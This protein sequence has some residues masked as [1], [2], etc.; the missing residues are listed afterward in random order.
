MEKKKYVPGKS[1]EEAKQALE[2]HKG[3]KPGEYHS[4]WKDAADGLL[5]DIQNR[6]PFSYH[7]GADPMYR[8][9]VDQYVRLGRKAMMDTM[10]KASAMTGGYGNSYAQTAGQQTY[11]EYLES[12]NDRLPEFQKMARDTYQAQGEDLLSRYEALSQ[13]EKDAYGQYQKILEQY[14]AQQD[15]LQGAYDREKEQDYHRYT[16]DRDFAYGQE[17]DEKQDAA[18]AAQAEREQKRWEEAKALEAERE[19]QKREQWQQEFNEDKRRFELQWASDHA[20]AAPN[21]ESGH[22]GGSG[23]G[24]RG[25]GNLGKY[26]KSHSNREDYYEKEKKKKT[27][28]FHH[29]KRPDGAVWSPKHNVWG[30]PNSSVA[31]R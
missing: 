30:R 1:V 3:K 5:H 22:G 2:N 18:A 15:R 28:Q 25:T 31:L 11:G 8:Q 20:P 10:G 26:Q 13:R 12:L 16:D 6:G 24:T 29:G 7:P 14:Y 23:R 27:E 21:P 19:R 17:R 4:Q 9:A